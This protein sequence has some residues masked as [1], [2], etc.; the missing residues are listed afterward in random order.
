LELERLQNLKKATVRKGL[1]LE[2]TIDYFLK[3]Q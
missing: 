2:N 1:S 3:K